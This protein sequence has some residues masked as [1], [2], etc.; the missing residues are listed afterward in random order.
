V[1]RPCNYAARVERMRSEL[2]VLV[3]SWIKDDF[4]ASVHEVALFLGAECGRAE[5]ER[6]KS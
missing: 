5:S 4:G 3:A 2:Y 6:S 1:T